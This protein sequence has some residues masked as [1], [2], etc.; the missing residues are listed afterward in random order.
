MP[1][2]YLLLFLTPFHY[3]P[4]LG[5]VLLDAGPLIITPVKILGLLTLVA[6]LVAPSPKNKA[7]RL[8]NPLV[9][10]FVAY[11]VF[12][13][14]TTVLFG[15]PTPSNYIGQYLSAALL[16]P[17]TRLLVSTEERMLK[18]TRALV[19]GFAFGSLWVYKQHFMH[20][21]RQAWGLEHDANYEA[22]MLLLAVAPAFWMAGYEEKHLLRRA[23]LIC[24]LL[25][26]G[27]VLLTQ[28]RA[29]VIAGTV[30]ALL[31]LVRSRRKLLGVALFAGAVIVVLNWGPNG[32]LQRFKHIKLEGAPASGDERSSRIHIE[33]LKAGVRMIEDH[34]IFGVGLGRFRSAAP[35]Y[36][37]E[38]IKLTGGRKF[39]AHDTF[40]Q[41]GS[42][43][44]IPVLL[45]FLIMLGVTRRNY[46]VAQQSSND[47]LA[48]L[49]ASMEMSLIGVSVVALSI[50]VEFLPF[51]ILILL[52]QN[53]REIARAADMV[54]A[55]NDYIISAAPPVL[56]RTGS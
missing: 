38:L 42:E 31:A 39:I 24:G 21:A 28:S 19:F 11:A 45:I 1:L 33:L 9:L 34:P 55:Q 56:L 50:S 40:L 22:L 26:A 35:L 51:C 25:L 53:L 44:G 12:P 7:E 16:F 15:L 37:P 8:R 5:F 32:L 49:G 52:S 10:L 20:H 47:R 14:A 17:A 18:V 46:R 4:R 27:A 36:N 43:A 29:G 41:I 23:G 2:Y 54:T 30:V 13:V 3:D 6:A 48:A